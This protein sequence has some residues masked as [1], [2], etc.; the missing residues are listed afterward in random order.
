M[1]TTKDK[2]EAMLKII[3]NNMKNHTFSEDLL[4]PYDFIVGL[5]SGLGVK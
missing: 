1:T 2:R 4:M 5:K 3:I